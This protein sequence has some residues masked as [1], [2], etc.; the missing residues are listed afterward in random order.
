VRITGLLRGLAD[1]SFGGNL[2]V[3]QDASFGGNVRI[4][5]LLRGLADA[6]FGGNLFVLRDASFGGNLTVLRDASFGGNVRI[7]GNLLVLNDVSF[8]GNLFVLRDASFGGNL[9]VFR[10]ASFGGNVR[11][12]GNLRVLNDVS[13]GGNLVVIKDGLINRNF[14]IGGDLIVNGSVTATAFNAMSDKRLKNNIQLLPSQWENIKMLQPSEYT[15]RDSYVRDYGFVA[16]QVFDIY[17]HMRTKFHSPTLENTTLDE[18]INI[19]GEPQYYSLDYSKM[20]T[21]LCKGLQETIDVIEK[22]QI[23]IDDLKRKIDSI[24]DRLGP[25][26]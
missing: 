2:T 23:E 12:F 1:A 4:T 20:T 5:G 16:Q 21:M 9:T 14:N 10:D 7:F 17:P 26:V 25:D 22:Q 11:I 8:G 18:P 6:S 13:F 15:W 3:L 24:Q 19:H